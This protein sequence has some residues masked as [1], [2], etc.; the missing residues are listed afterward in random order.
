M[1]DPRTFSICSQLE[2]DHSP[3]EFVDVCHLLVQPAPNQARHYVMCR[4]PCQSYCKEVYGPLIDAGS[5]R[6][7][8]P[9]YWA[10]F[11]AML[12]HDQEDVNR[13]NLD[14]FTYAF[15]HAL[16]QVPSWDCSN[17]ALRSSAIE[18]RTF[19]VYQFIPMLRSRQGH[20]YLIPSTGLTLQE[21][22]DLGY[23][24]LTLFSIIDIGKD[25]GKCYINTSELGSRLLE[26]RAIP[27]HTFIMDVWTAHPARVT[28]EWFKSLRMLLNIFQK[29]TIYQRMKAD[30]GCAEFS[31]GDQTMVSVHMDVAMPGL[32][33]GRMSSLITELENW[34]Q[35][36]NVNGCNNLETLTMLNGFGL[37]R[38]II[39]CNQSL[40]GLVRILMNKVMVSA[41]AL[42]SI[43]RSLML[44]QTN[45]LQEP[46]RNLL[47]ALH[48][49]FS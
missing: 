16:H 31:G 21:A 6:G 1:R 14:T 10:Y 23:L 3:C 45:P 49:C 9:S 42:S 39:C 4:E 29:W 19:H 38:R 32:I 25:L 12:Y 36:S 8:F 30:H 46:R 20:P 35:I 22:N 27:H 37:C 24:V 40:N 47:S 48:L 13:F 15:C 7:I 33:H 26:W 34:D 18:G 44:K 17:D 41:L 43:P 5:T 2:R 28:Y 11:Q